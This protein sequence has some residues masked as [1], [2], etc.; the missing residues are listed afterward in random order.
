MVNKLMKHTTKKYE[1]RQQKNS[2]I[3]AYENKEVKFIATFEKHFKAIKKAWDY[4]KTLAPYYNKVSTNWVMSA[5]QE[6][7]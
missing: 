2:K 7:I 3:Y 4:F 1:K 6:T 5:K